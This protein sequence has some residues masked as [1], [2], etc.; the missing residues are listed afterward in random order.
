MRVPNHT[1]RPWTAG[2]VPPK[3]RTATA[4]LFSVLALALVVWLVVIPATRVQAATY[5]VNTTNDADDG[6]CN[7][8]H[9]SLREAINAANGTA[10]DDVI[11]FAAGGAIVLAAGLPAITDDDLV[12]NGGGQQIS[13]TAPGT[14]ISVNADRVHLNNLVVDGEGIGTIG[15]LI[16]TTTDDLIIDGVTVRDFTDDGFDNSGGGGGQRNTVRNST[17]TANKGN[18]V[19]FNGGQND[20]VRGNL[21]TGNG[22]GIGDHGLQVSNEEGL[23][24]QG[25]T[26]SGNFDAQIHIAGLLAGQHVSIIQNTITSGSDG[27]TVGGAVDNAANID[28]GLSVENR[29][30]FR[31]VI[32][33]PAEQHLRN[34]SGA[35]ID[36]IYN[37]W[38]AYSPAAIEGVICHNNEAACGAGVV[39]FEPFVDTPSPLP[40]ATG[41]PT[42]TVTPGGE[43]ATPT[44]T[45][46]VT[47]GDVETV[48]LVAGCNPTAWTGT[49]ATPIATIAGAVSPAGILVALWQFEGGVWL[50]Y[51]PEFPDVSDL[52]TMDR[53]DVAFICVNAAGTFSRPII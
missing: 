42:A 5:T 47:P 10:E 50:G 15:I 14:A 27:I 29:N 19:D 31:G 49:N 39:D 44:A 26:L 8:T 43:T 20:V 1:H 33:A 2:H 25:N 12:V 4:A 17:F 32:A 52:T 23:V 38:D 51:S 21:I 34:L 6:T 28:I 24:V 11:G 9:C 41:T 37:D 22:D 18:G 40:T 3:G 16:S 30:V 45:G 13:L 35:P 53:L 46:T 7:G 48:A 36:A